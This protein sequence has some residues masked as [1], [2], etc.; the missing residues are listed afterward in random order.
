MSDDAQTPLLG[1]IEIAA[2]LG[3]SRQRVYQLM[4]QPD[5]PDPVATLGCGRIWLVQD[6]DHY[7][8]H[9]WKRKESKP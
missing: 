7:R 3:I 9:V 2:R 4:D 6:V 5:F 8:D 1:A